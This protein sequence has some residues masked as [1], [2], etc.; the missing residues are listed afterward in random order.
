MPAA[1][2]NSLH[3]LVEAEIKMIRE[4]DATLADLLD[5]PVPISSP[6][7]VRLQR[8]SHLRPGRGLEMVLRGG[9][10]PPE[11]WGIWSEGRRS[12]LQLA[13]DRA[14][15]LPIALDFELRGFIAPGLTQSVRVSVNARTVATLEF[16]PSRP[17]RTETVEINAEDVS[18]DFAAQI[19]FDIAHP[20]A[21]AD[22]EPS[23][24][25]RKLGIGISSLRVS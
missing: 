20:T 16:D 14:S 24:D 17:E 1:V 6:E 8:G 10:H 5:R 9:W 12:V 3:R 18:A 11:E 4:R 13:F 22:V 15:G 23:S 7:L 25:R 21:P 19:A 2:V